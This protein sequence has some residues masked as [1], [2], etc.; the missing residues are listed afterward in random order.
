MNRAVIFD[1]RD[2]YL[3]GL[4]QFGLDSVTEHADEMVRKMR[5]KV[6]EDS[7]L[8]EVLTQKVAMKTSL[9]NGETDTLLREQLG[10]EEASEIFLGPLVSE[11]KVVAILYGDNL[12]EKKLIGDVEAFEVFISQAGMAME[13]V[14]L[15]RQLNGRGTI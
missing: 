15:E 12:P 10:G 6:S 14:L 3:V 9:G 8:H 4:G 5:L 7:V 11:G 1:V 13:K 2:D